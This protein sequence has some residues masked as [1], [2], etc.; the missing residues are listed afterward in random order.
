MA[1]VQSTLAISLLLSSLRAAGAFVGYLV[2]GRSRWC[3]TTSNSVLL[4]QIHEKRYL[5]KKEIIIQV[6][7]VAYGPA[8]A[9]ARFVGL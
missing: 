5:D 1:S 6:Q 2:P 3:K 7:V 9:Y 8:F 4:H